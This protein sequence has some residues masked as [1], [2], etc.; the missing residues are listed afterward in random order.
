MPGQSTRS[1]GIAAQSE[2]KSELFTQLPGVLKSGKAGLPSTVH[3]TPARFRIAVRLY[4]DDTQHHTVVLQ[5]LKRFR[6][7]STL[8]SALF[9]LFLPRLELCHCLS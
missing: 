5:S 2:F 7:L 8:Y 3:V 1:F 6:R 4:P 9:G